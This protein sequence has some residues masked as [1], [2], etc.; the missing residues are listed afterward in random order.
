M[1]RFVFLMSFLILFGLSGVRAVDLHSE[2][3]KEKNEIADSIID[4]SY[5]SESDMPNKKN[6]FRILW[7]PKGGIG[8]FVPEKWTNTESHAG[9]SP[10]FGCA[11]GLTV[12]FEWNS[13]W[14]VEP[15]LMLAYG[16]SSVPVYFRR[17]EETPRYGGDYH[18][19]RGAVQIPV[20]FGFKFR[21]VNDYH[22]SVFTGGMVSCGFAGS[23]EAP[24]GSPAFSLYGEDGVW[25]RMSYAVALGFT[26]ESGLPL[27]FS[28]EFYTGM[29]QMARKDI[30]ETHR[31]SECDMRVAMA[32]R[33]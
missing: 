25:K 1:M 17:A 3:D 32:Y 23:F 2:A 6:Q 22:M 29:N 16:N 15:A 4:R 31:V 19:S 12:R 18:M 10:G 33:F 28:L 27:V 26:L 21:I 30:F 7:G 24:K 14:Y 5:D 9:R 20:H 11:A 13:R 8:F